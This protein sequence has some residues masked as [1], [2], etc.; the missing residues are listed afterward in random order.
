VSQ[1]DSESTKP[2]GILIRRPTSNVYTGMLGVAAVSL[3]LGCLF[4][5]L[6]IMQY[7]LFSAP[8]KNP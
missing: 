3:A 8:W 1:P 4:L 2:G 5:L 7:D 6:E